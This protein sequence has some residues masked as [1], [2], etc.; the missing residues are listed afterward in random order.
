M[1]QHLINSKDD[2]PDLIWKIISGAIKETAGRNGGRIKKNDIMVSAFEY[3]EYLRDIFAD[4]GIDGGDI[5]NLANWRYKT[6]KAENDRGKFWKWKNL[7]KKGSLA[8]DWASGYTILLNQ[9]SIDWTK[10]FKQ[11]GFPEIIGHD[12]EVDTMERI[13]SRELSLIHI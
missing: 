12:E 6:R 2:E 5:R 4:Q 9:Y 10:N 8:K 7:V 13:L 11:N 1:R 3:H